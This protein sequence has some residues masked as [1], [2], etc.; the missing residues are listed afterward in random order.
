MKI[1]GTAAFI[2]VVILSAAKN[3][4]L[5]LVIVVAGLVE[6]GTGVGDPGYNPIARDSSLRSE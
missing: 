5:F 6:G 2:C 4:S 1:A 3:L